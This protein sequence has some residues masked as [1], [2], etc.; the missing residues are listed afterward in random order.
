[1]D[2]QD[3]MISIPAFPPAPGTPEGDLV[4]A[5]LKTLYVDHLGHGH[6]PA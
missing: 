2:Y 4:R 3:M 5:A 1:L 6:M